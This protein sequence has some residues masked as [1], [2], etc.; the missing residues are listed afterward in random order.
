MPL[1]GLPS[2]TRPIGEWCAQ[3]QVPTLVPTISRYAVTTNAA[4]YTSGARPRRMNAARNRNR[5]APPTAGRPLIAPPQT[6]QAPAPTSTGR[7]NQ[8]PA[9]GSVHGAADR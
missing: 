9:A 5:T 8:L 2:E 1:G 6:A 7:G 3:A 4:A